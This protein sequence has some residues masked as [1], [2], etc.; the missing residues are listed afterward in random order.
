M[1]FSNGKYLNIIP[2]DNIIKFY[3]IGF[4]L[5]NKFLDNNLFHMMLYGLY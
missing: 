4:T 2:I 5:L 1:F 3:T